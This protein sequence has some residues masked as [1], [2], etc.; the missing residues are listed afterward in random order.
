MH[1]TPRQPCRPGH[2]AVCRPEKLR[3]HVPSE[4]AVLQQIKR[5]ATGLLV[6]GMALE[7]SLAGE[8]RGELGWR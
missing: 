2:K 4:L 1:A 5:E 7:L 6:D 8:G 3:P